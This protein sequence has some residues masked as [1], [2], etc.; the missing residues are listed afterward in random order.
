MSSLSFYQREI[1]Q[2]T[3]CQPDQAQEI[4][5]YMRNMIFDGNLGQVKC[6]EFSRGAIEAFHMVNLLPLDIQFT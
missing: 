6:S 5:D 3:G 1:V 2:I 4:E